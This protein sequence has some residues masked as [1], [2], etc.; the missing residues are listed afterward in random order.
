MCN[1]STG[2]GHLST[3]H[4]ICLNVATEAWPSLSLPGRELS[5]HLCFSPV[6]HS[7]LLLGLLPYMLSAVKSILD[8][9]LLIC[10]KAFPLWRTSNKLE[11]ERVLL[12]SCILYSC[13]HMLES[14]LL[15]QFFPDCTFYKLNLLY[16]RQ[17]ADPALHNMQAWVLYKV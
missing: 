6:F 15:Y 17:W 7:R 1:H 11:K 3:C 9:F 5:D 13:F 8:Y 16:S 4:A 14:A 2:R 10:D 12:H